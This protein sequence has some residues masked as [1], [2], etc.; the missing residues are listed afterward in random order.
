MAQLPEEDKKGIYAAAAAYGLDFDS[1]EW[2]PFAISQHG[3]LAIQHA[4]EALGAAVKEGS[5]YAIAQAM[6][7]LADAKDTELEK[8]QAAAAA[9][10]ASVKETAEKARQV[11]EALSA[12]AQSDIVRGVSATVEEK[13]GEIVSRQVQALDG[14]QR[15]L[16][17]SV[18]AAKDRMTQ[19]RHI[20]AAQV[21]AWAGMGG[22]IGGLLV[23]FF[24]WWLVS[25]GHVQ[26]PPPQVNMDAQAVGQYIVNALRHK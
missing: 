2:I 23:G 17:Q 20:G 21:L 13:T 5:D 25:S 8:L 11:I 6:K 22:L 14:A 16:V 19:I 24:M 1:P 9:S 4:I 7:A 15:A 10:Q 26:S 3:L 12:K 18:D